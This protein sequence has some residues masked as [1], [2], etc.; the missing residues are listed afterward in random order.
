MDWTPARIAALFLALWVALAP[1]VFAVPA[2][3]M[4]SQMSMS[5]DPNSDGCDSCPD[6]NANRSVCALVCV[7]A[8]LLATQAQFGNLVPVVFRDD[9]PLSRDLARSGRT[10]TPDPPPPKLFAVP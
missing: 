5:S 9:H 1:A 10:V 7:N 8:F 3:A 4:M 6:A 2:A